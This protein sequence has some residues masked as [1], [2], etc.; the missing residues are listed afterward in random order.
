[1][2]VFCMTISCCMGTLDLHS[3]PRAHGEELMGTGALSVVPPL[4]DMY[5][6]HGQAVRVNGKTVR[7]QVSTI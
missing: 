6:S 4:W 5:V 7:F 1:M 3:P 2:G